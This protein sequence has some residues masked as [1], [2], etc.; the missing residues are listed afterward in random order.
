MRRVPMALPVHC[1]FNFARWCQS[2]T[3]APPAAPV[4]V[5]GAGRAS[6]SL[7]STISNRWLDSPSLSNR[8]RVVERLV[9]VFTC[10]PSINKRTG[11]ASGT[12]LSVVSVNTLAVQVQ[13]LGATGFAS[14]RVRHRSGVPSGKP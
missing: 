12:Q 6:T 7:Y 4:V 9:P 5:V 2:A 11:R 8:H 1:A 3:R 14:A 10:K 13:Y